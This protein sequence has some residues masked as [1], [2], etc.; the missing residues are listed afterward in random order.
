MQEIGDT[1]VQFFRSGG[2]VM[3][4]LLLGSVIALTIILEKLINLRRG[5]IIKPRLLKMIKRLI[6]EN[7]YFGAETICDE[8]PSVMTTIIQAAIINRELGRDEI[9]EAIL[10]A[11]RQH[12]P[13]LERYLG[14]LGSIASA[15]PLL[16]LLGTVTGMI[17]VFK[18]IAQVG[19]GQAEAL[20]GGISE[21]LITTATGLVIAIPALIAYN[22]FIE[23]SENLLLEIEKESMNV[24]NMIL[25]NQK[26]GVSPDRDP[27]IRDQNSGTKERND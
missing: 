17:K 1:I 26:S 20:S 14:I 5:A 13:I 24:M 10:D 3:I 12:I 27:E 6:R 23:K 19:V 15:S 8:N 4:P 22:Y 9:K 25:A 11:G 16:G 18:V 2:I 21:A 7:D